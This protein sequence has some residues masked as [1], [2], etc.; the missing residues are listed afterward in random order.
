MQSYDVIIIGAGPA[1]LNAA[2]I[3]GDAGKTVLLLEKNS[4]IGPKVCAGGLTRKSIQYLNLPDEI[5][6]CRYSRAVFNSKHFRT[7]VNLSETFFFTIDRKNLGQW[8]L[9]LL[10]RRNVSVMTE[11]YV[12]KIE[13]DFVL[14]NDS[15]KFYYKYL[16]GAD[17]SNSVVR[18]YLKIKTRLAGVAIQ[19]KIPAGR[20]H[21]FELFCDSRLFNTWYSW[22]FPLKNYASVGYGYPMKFFSPVKAQKKF[23][24][25]A[26]EKRI[27]LAGIP[28]ESFL[29]NCDWRGFKFGNIFLAGDAA[30]L[31]SDFTGEGIYQALISADDIAKTIL[32][33]NHKP[34]KILRAVREKRI[35]QFFMV[36]VFC[37]WFLR[38]LVFDAVALSLR[39]K[40]LG[41]IF[42]R[43]FS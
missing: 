6:D 7:E 28:R 39:N 4:V 19:Y 3:L 40:T 22:I 31:A 24:E 13:K 37:S 34:K 33:P 27:N 18:R 25:W 9:S 17:G 41:R 29:I 14:V 16:I 5:T 38:N 10:D 2:K 36:I 1:G 42:F 15:Q 11:S 23:E 26:A 20:F 8:Q 32:N 12:S 43:I 21:D 30:G 35:H